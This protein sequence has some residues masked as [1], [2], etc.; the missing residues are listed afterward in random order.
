MSGLRTCAKTL[1]I[2]TFLCSDA[3]TEERQP[4]HVRIDQL[5]SASDVTVLPAAPPADDAVFL[6]RV[7][8]DL[9]GVIPPPE[10]VREFLSDGS[11]DKRVKM[12]D[13]LI[14]GPEYAW[15]MS[16]LFDALLVQRQREREDD[17]IS[18]E[19]WR[20]YLLESFQQNKPW[21]QLVVEILS[22]DGTD[23]RL[24]PAARFYFSRKGDIGQLISDISGIFLGRNIRCAQCHDHPSIDEYRQADFFGLAA[25]YSRLEP[26]M[27]DGHRVLVERPVGTTTFTSALTSTEGTTPPRIFDGP[28]LQEPDAVK[29]LQD[30][31]EKSVIR[32]QTATEAAKRATDALET[33]KKIEEPDDHELQVAEEAATRALAEKDMAETKQRAAESMLYVVPPAENV[34]PIPIFSRRSYLAPMVLNHPSF[35]RNIANR[36]WAMMMGRGLVE[37]LDLDY[38][39]NPA[40]HPALLSMLADEFAAMDFNIASFLRE[41]ALT[42]IYGRS[43]IPRD[44]PSES[45]SAAFTVATARKLTPEQ[46]VWSWMR[47]TGRFEVEFQAIERESEQQESIDSVKHQTSEQ[48]QTVQIHQRLHE[49]MESMVKEFVSSIPGEVD[50]S[51]STPEQALFLLNSSLVSEWLKPQPGNLIDRL[52]NI[53]EVDELAQELFI[54]VLSRPAAN[55]ETAMVHEQMMAAADEERSKVLAD[56][57]WSLLAS[58]EFRFN[59]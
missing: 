48:C 18:A 50:R 3:A 14:A 55:E 47:A 5:I 26:K 36:L 22:S 44:G 53:Q 38:S 52:V 40:V 15:H 28:V 54:S 23:T 31:Y 46:L 21:N 35:R 20:G 59:H 13:R 43:S 4:L 16:G 49:E 25:F 39:E 33:L 27:V 51:E 8:L 32:A 29:A 6:R 58:A 30:A 24:R 19:P 45:D 9:N 41:L 11:A 57:A 12:I 42:K 17:V 1:L 7:S 10:V 56:L 34:R 37:P 2:L